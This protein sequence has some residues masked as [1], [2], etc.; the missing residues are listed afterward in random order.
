MAER[1][2]TA[3]VTE[4]LTKIYHGKQIALSC[5]NLEVEPGTEIGR[6]HV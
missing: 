3:I 1:G 5:V 2:Q 6:A 4:S